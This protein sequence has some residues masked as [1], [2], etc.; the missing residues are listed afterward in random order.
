MTVNNDNFITEL[1]TMTDFNKSKFIRAIEDENIRL[2]LLQYLDN[3]YY[4]EEVIKTF[5][6]ETLKLEGIKL[7]KNSS[8]KAKLISSLQDI[9]ILS[10]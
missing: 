4:K 3:D 7:V 10:Q 6:N 9:N 8:I 5:T 2:S 1:S